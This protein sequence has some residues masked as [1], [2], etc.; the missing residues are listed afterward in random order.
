MV[1]GQAEAGEEAGEQVLSEFHLLV[2]EGAIPE[3]REKIKLAKESGLASAQPD[4]WA[5][6]L[7]PPTTR[8]VKAGKRTSRDKEFAWIRANAA[9]Y[10]GQWLA[11]YEDRLVASGEALTEVLKTVKEQGAED[12][13]LLHFQ[14]RQSWRSP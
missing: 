8:V 5:R 11:L 7:E 13:V 6:F 4:R 2:A 10:E 9:R 14:P 12:L 1:S 3:A